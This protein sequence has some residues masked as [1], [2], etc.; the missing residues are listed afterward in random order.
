ML[1]ATTNHV[2]QDVAVVP[3]LWVAPLALYLL[4]FIICFDHASWYWRRPYAAAA[5]LQPGRADRRRSIDH[6]RIGADLSLLARTGAAS[7][8]PVLFVHGLP[9]RTVSPAA[10]SA[11]VD[12]LL[13]ADR[14]G[15]RRGG[16]VRQPV[17]PAPV[18]HV[19]RMADRPG[20]RPVD[21]G[22]GLARRS[23][24]IVFPPAVRPRGHGGLADLRRP[25]L[26]A[27]VARRRRGDVGPQFFWRRFGP[28][29]ACRRSR[30]AHPRFL[31]RPHRARAGVHGGRQA[32]ASR[33]LITAARPAW[34]RRLPSWPIGRG[35]GSGLSGWASARSPP[36][37]GRETRSVFMKSIPT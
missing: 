30:P 5:L 31:Q 10:R 12:Q 20:R 18:H 2:C 26:R 15:R 28:R 3:F 33:P 27:A 8:G 37:P 14:G 1:L 17:G 29:A 24:P 19:F 11:L 13:S 25:E 4:S 35:C 7:G 36:M 34:A 6:R 21:V 32:R 16:H 22:L 23:G 9:R